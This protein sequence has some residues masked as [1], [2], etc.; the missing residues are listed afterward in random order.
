VNL[1]NRIRQ[2]EVKEKE[3]SLL[4][5]RQMKEL[6]KVANLSIED[7]KNYLLSL[8]EDKIKHEKVAILRNHEAKVKAE[9]EQIS[10]DI[11][12]TAIQKYAP[13]YVAESTVSVV[14][15]PSDDMKGRIIGREG[16]NIR[17]LETLTGIE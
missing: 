14:S 17:T 12:A 7:A 16:R 15:L 13:E 9:S 8:L 5:D 3:V 2:M 1:S 10:Q 4:Q 11:I 6:E